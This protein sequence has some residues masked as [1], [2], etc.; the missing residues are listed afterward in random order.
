METNNLVKTYASKA[1]QSALMLWLLQ[2]S[3]LCM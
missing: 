2:D 1:V 3:F